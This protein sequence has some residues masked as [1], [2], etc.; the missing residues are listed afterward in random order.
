MRRNKERDRDMKKIIIAILSCVFVI[1]MVITSFG[2]PSIQG[3]GAK[4]IG[5]FGALDKGHAMIAPLGAETT[6]LPE[7]V[8]ASIKSINEGKSISE[9]TGLKEFAEY[10]ALGKTVAILTTDA[11]G[12]ILDVPTKL[13]IYVPNM[14]EGKDIK[15]IAYTNITGLWGPTQVLGL[16]YKKKSLD[17]LINGSSTICVV[18]KERFARKKS[19]GEKCKNG[20]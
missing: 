2:A 10:K 18:Y 9:A 1:S 7:K 19:M 4:T 11:T 13:S 15:V 12:K 20:T 8:V 17:I 6:G 16:N 5:L 14:V 3:A